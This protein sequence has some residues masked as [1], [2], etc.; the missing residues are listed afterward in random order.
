MDVVSIMFL[1]YSKT[2]LLKEFGKLLFQ[3]QLANVS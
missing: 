2:F 1:V 3:T